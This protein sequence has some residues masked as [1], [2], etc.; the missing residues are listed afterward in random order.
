M[1][2]NLR[3]YNRYAVGDSLGPT[4]NRLLANI[5]GGSPSFQVRPSD[6]G[7]TLAIVISFY[8]EFTGTPTFK[9]HRYGPNLVAVRLR[10]AGNNHV[11]AYG[12][13]N[14]VG[15]EIAPAT[16]T[17]TVFRTQSGSRVEEMQRLTFP[18]LPETGTFI[19]GYGGGG[20]AGGGVGP[21]G[22]SQRINV[23]DGAAGIQ[24]ALRQMQLVA[25]INNPPTPVGSS[26][27]DGI[28]ASG[29]LNS[30][31]VLI[32]YQRGNGGNVGSGLVPIPVF[33][34]GLD[35]QYA[36][37]HNISVALTASDYTD[38]FLTTN[39]P[40]YLEV[41]VDGAVSAQY[42]LTSSITP[43]QPPVA[44]FVANTTQA[45]IGSAIIFTDL[46]TN[47]PTSWIWDFGDGNFSSSANPSHAYLAA[48]TYTV[49]LTAVNS[50]GQN[51]A[52][53]TGYILIVGSP[54]PGGGGPGLLASYRNGN[55]NVLDQSAGA[56]FDVF[57]EWPG[58]TLWHV[59]Y[60]MDLDAYNAL[61]YP[62]VGSFQ[63]PFGYFVR[64]TP[65]K[66][67][68]DGIIEFERLLHNLPGDANRPVSV[69]KNYQ[70]GDYTF[71]NGQL[72][73]IAI[74]SFSRP[75]KA[76]CSFHYAL[77]DPGGLPAIP[78]I[79]IVPFLHG[80]LITDLG[81]GFPYANFNGQNLPN[82]NYG[83][84]V[85]DGSSIEHIMGNLFCRKIIT[86]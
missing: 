18:S 22:Y 66:Y 39:G 23:A 82:N 64:D 32:E 76:N 15:S 19:M 44:D 33:T 42:L 69:S 83:V 71:T 20:I 78:F 50:Y 49:K 2:I 7:N 85:M 10:A 55:F 41:L 46:S 47:A 3:L 81:S 17:P 4:N 57:E 59:P 24:A 21:Q 40:A 53:K 28:F 54:G 61:G 62:A 74:I 68:G 72:T 56:Y 77:N 67:I 25:W 6:A 36:F 63:P 26:Y 45:S 30:P 31:G 27:A 75:I 70:A 60:V 79:Q 34:T 43:G 35:V 65:W 80:Q 8:D 86:G 84:S 14:Y 48:G 16:G 1:S 37:G 5:L 38:L 29:T 51:L 52:T 12:D 9:N 13:N 11:Y 73:D 58:L